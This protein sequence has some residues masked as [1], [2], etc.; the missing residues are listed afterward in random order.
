M[1]E[2]YGRRRPRR[3][4]SFQDVQAPG[5]AMAGVPRMQDHASRNAALVGIQEVDHV[6]RKALDHL[7]AVVG[8][9]RRTTAEA[10]HRMFDG[11]R[12]VC[13][14]GIHVVHD[15]HRITPLAFGRDELLRRQRRARRGAIRD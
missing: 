6:G 1:R 3:H 10:L 4:L 15:R 7:R 13:R 8:D 9:L 2:L 14:A 5:P 11:G 12:L